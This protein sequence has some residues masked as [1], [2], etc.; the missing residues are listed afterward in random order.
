[1]KIPVSGVRFPPR[2]PFG[3]FVKCKPCNAFER[4]R[5]FLC[6]AGPAN[7]WLR[8]AP[9]SFIARSRL[10][11]PQPTKSS[12]RASQLRQQP[13]RRVLLGRLRPLILGGADSIAGASS[14]T[15]ET[16]QRLGRRDLLRRPLSPRCLRDKPSP[17]NFS[18]HEVLRRIGQYALS[19]DE[20]SH[21]LR[22]TPTTISCIYS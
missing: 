21:D 4:C 17:A 1:M 15:S 9:G 7:S 19:A 6:R 14:P 16:R 5:V 18:S 22:H 8:V 10:M 2:P 13:F 12:L 3:G 11:S 20:R